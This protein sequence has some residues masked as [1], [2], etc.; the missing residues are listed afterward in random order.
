MDLTVLQ[1]QTF[2]PES[3]ITSITGG[4]LQYGHWEIEQVSTSGGNFGTD[5]ITGQSIDLTPYTTIT[6]VGQSYESHTGNGGNHQSAFQLY[7]GTATVLYSSPWHN[8]TININETIDISSITGSYQ[9]RLFDYNHNNG[10][11][12]RVTSGIL[13]T[14]IILS[15]KTVSI[16]INPTGAGTVTG[17]GYYKSG[18]SVTIEATPNTGYLFDHFS[19]NG[20]DITTNPYTFTITQDTSVIGYFKSAECTLNLSVSPQDSGYINIGWKAQFPQGL[21]S[22]GSVYDEINETKA[23]KRVES[24]DLGTLNYTRVESSTSGV[25][26]FVTDINSIPIKAVNS[27]VGNL[28]CV[29]FTTDTAYNI[30]LG[31]ANDKS[32]G[33]WDGSGVRI[34]DDSY[35]DAT[36]FKNAMQG[37]ILNYELATPV[38]TDITFDYSYD[39]VNGGTESVNSSVPIIADIL[40]PSG[41]KTD[42]T[43]ISR[44]TTEDGVAKVKVLKGNTLKFNQLVDSA[45]YQYDGGFTSITT[46]TGKRIQANGTL[47]TGG[48]LNVIHRN[49]FF[50]SKFPIIKKTANSC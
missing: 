4:K 21:R 31:R 14:S 18:D 11:T 13:L 1:G 42:Q 32:I 38:E 10:G 24:V 46:I 26:F 30:Y 20:T 19:V 3:G 41:L 34:R 15:N 25:Y 44:Q 43:F 47:S 7:N 45:K 8:G 9:L 36:S 48:N 2:T 23:I 27:Q 40:Y 5:S 12:A 17:G 16:T 37:V 33:A 50:M 49:N 6:I 29:P 39:I 22:A 28:V 35:T